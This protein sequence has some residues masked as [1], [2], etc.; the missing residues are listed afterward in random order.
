MQRWREYLKELL[1]GTDMLALHNE[2][3]PDDKRDIIVCIKKKK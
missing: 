3:I 2:R 1:E